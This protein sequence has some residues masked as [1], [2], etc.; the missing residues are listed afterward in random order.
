MPMSSKSWVCPICNKNVR[1]TEY[2]VACSGCKSYFHPKCINISDSEVKSNKTLNYTCNKCSAGKRKSGEDVERLFDSFNSKV[3]MQMEEQV[4]KCFNGFREILDRAVE[5]LR[6]EFS[7]ALQQLQ[8]VVDD[9]KQELLHVRNK[10]VMLLEEITVCKEQY[11]NAERQNMIQQRRLNRADILIN[12]LPQSIRNLRE[13]VTKV[14]QLCNVQLHPCDIQH[15]CYIYGGKT[16]LVKFNSIHIRDK[17]MANY[18]RTS[19]RL[20]DIV[21]CDV[22]SR[23]YLKD[24]LTPAA[25]RLVNTCR[26]LRD[27][28]KVHKY[29]LINGDVPMVRLTF[30]DGN[31]IDQNADQCQEMLDS[32][33]IP[34]QHN[35][36]SN[37]D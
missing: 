4:Q 30:Q 2:S 20:K 10:N 9:C 21:D 31:E 7:G 34:V 6:V 3:K 13:P 16:I 32:D 33:V 11:K 29:V 22:Q 5:A 35:N 24:H 28:K 26:K 15:C 8:E 36:Q 37:E 14:A 18:F 27:R 25:A 12:G 17:I 19:I 23:I 1:K